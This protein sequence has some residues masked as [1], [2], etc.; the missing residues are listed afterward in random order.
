MAKKAKVKSYRHK[1]KPQ[2]HYEIILV[3]F[4]LLVVILLGWKYSVRSP[5]EPVSYNYPQGY[6]FYGYAPYYMWGHVRYPYG[7]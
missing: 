5:N 3:L 7:F 4:I 2:L 6:V 1:G